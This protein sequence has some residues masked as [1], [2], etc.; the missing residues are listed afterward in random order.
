MSTQLLFVPSHTIQTKYHGVLFRSRIEARW[1]VFYDAMKIEWEYEKEGYQ[2]PG[3]LGA[4]LPDFWIPSL[5]CWV[6]IKGKSPS[7]EEQERCRVLANL[8]GNMVY[9]FYGKIPSP[10]P[11]S[12][13]DGDESSHA[14]FPDLGE[15]YGYWWCR[16]LTCGSVGIEYNGRSDR[17]KCKKV[18]T[19]L[20][21][22]HGDKGYTYDH[23]FL[24][25][26]YYLA[27]SAR[28]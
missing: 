23:D 16:C 3:N 11:E 5:S 10:N 2:L 24:V 19:C 15:D 26:A 7:G 25:Q 8:T 9:L 21:S 1:A 17:L 22:S 14:Y 18:G 13:M 4:Y 6:E 12:G 27:S 20:K 28:F